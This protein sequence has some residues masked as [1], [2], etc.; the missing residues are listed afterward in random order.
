MTSKIIERLVKGSLAAKGF[1]DFHKDNL[2]YFITYQSGDVGIYQANSTSKYYSYSKLSLTEDGIVSS[3][4]S[5]KAFKL[6]GGLNSLF[7][8]I[9]S[10][11]GKIGNLTKEEFDKADGIDDDFV[12]EVHI[13]NP[14]SPVKLKLLDMAEYALSDPHKVL[15]ST[16]NHYL[17]ILGNKQLVKNDLKTLVG[18]MTMAVMDLINSNKD[19]SNT[20]TI[21]GMLALNIRDTIFRNNTIVTA[22]NALVKR[23]SGF[24]LPRPVSISDLFIRS[25]EKTPWALALEFNLT[26]SPFAYLVP[27]S[28]KQ[29][30]IGPAVPPS[31]PFVKIMA[32]PHKVAA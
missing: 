32:G 12:L 17:D 24:N 20:W 26:V 31:D 2:S 29:D 15:L 6:D 25:L 21:S 9:F 7:D 27:L 28:E 10:S 3:I 5:P 30:K 1:I 18:L 14:K 13:Y 16:S 22:Y 23:A 8:S 4:K 11:N 19:G